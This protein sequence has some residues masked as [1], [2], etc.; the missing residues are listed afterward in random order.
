[1]P[2]SRIHAVKDAIARVLADRQIRAGDSSAASGGDILFLEALI[3]RGGEAHVLLPFQTDAFVATSVG[4]L[5][6]PRFEQR[7]RAIGRRAVALADRVPDDPSL[8]F[9]NCHDALVTAAHDEGELL[10]EIPILIALVSPGDEVGVGGAA[11]IMNTWATR[12]RGEILT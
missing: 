1:F 8:A 2:P 11:E 7:L 10:D 5:W 6:R 12:A 9:R 4:E 3:E